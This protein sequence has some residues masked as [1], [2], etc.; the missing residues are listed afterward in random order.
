MRKSL[1]ILF[2]ISILFSCERVIDITPVDVEQELVVNGQISLNEKDTLIL[3]S[4]GSIETVHTSVSGA[5]ITVTYQKDTVGRYIESS[6]GIYCYEGKSFQEN[7]MYGLK[8]EHQDY[9]SV[10]AET[11]IP[12]VPE[13]SFATYS[14]NQEKY[15]EVFGANFQVLLEFEDDGETDDYYIISSSFTYKVIVLDYFDPDVID[16]IIIGTDRSHLNSR[17]SFVEMIIT[18]NNINLVQNQIDWEGGYHPWADEVV[19]SDKFFNGQKITVP[20]DF[21]LWNMEYTTKLSLT[22]TAI[23]EEYY[24]LLRSLAAKKKNDEGF[25][26]EPLQMYSNVEN[27]QGVWAAKASKTISLE[28][29]GA[30]LFE[31]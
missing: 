28:I 1:Y 17:S 4:T 31:E 12:V 15:K 29:N 8:V 2:I 9:S 13:I 30:Q 19:F 7:L 27:G 10:C 20:L 25:F 18:R 26:P 16:T 3:T 14:D 5:N 11:K 6:D 21:Y 22:L 24:Q 23:S